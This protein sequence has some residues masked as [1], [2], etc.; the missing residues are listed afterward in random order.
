MID[1][2]KSHL[3][4]EQISDVRIFLTKSSSL[5]PQTFID[6]FKSKK[7]CRYLF[8]VCITP[9]LAGVNVT[10]DGVLDGDFSL[11]VSGHVLTDVDVA[12]L[13]R[14]QRQLDRCPHRVLE[15]EAKHKGNMNMCW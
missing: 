4:Y 9:Y 2:Q 7:C 3:S 15:T 12:E 13:R 14:V 10:P 6:V 8:S 11:A 1:V 5:A